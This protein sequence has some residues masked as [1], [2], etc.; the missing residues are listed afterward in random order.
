MVLS[1]VL[2][3]RVQKALRP[4]VLNPQ[5]SSLWPTCR[6]LELSLPASSLALGVR[7][8][9]VRTGYKTLGKDLRTSVRF[10]FSSRHHLHD[11]IA[12][13]CYY[14]SLMLS[15]VLFMFLLYVHSRFLFVYSVGHDCM[16]LL[17]PSYSPLLSLYSLYLYLIFCIHIFF[18]YP[19]N[20]PHLPYKILP[21]PRIPR[22][23]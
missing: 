8:A 22:A 10:K 23:V 12:H 1:P 3:T 2:C 20:K 9:N 17:L 18:N 19:Y 13:L 5:R 21:N 7:Q 4:F 6:I 11:T 14:C 16:Y 15:F